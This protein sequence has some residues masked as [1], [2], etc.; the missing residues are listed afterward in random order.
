[1]VISLEGG[2]IPWNQPTRTAFHTIHTITKSRPGA[3]THTIQCE[4]PSR[5]CSVLRS[6]CKFMLI[7]FWTDTAKINLMGNLFYSS[8]YR[9]KRDCREISETINPW[10]EGKCS[11]TGAVQS[12]DVRGMIGLCLGVN[13][14]TVHI[15]TIGEQLKHFRIHSVGL[16]RTLALSSLPPLLISNRHQYRSVLRQGTKKYCV[17]R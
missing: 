17:H 7:H 9:T 6:F 12:L 16:S 1:M 2:K 11:V 13:S 14:T 15:H 5:S 3:Y 4:L 8:N 10:M